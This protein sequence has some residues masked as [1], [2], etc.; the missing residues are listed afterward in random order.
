MT[1]MTSREYAQAMADQ[2]GD[3]AKCTWLTVGELLTLY[4]QID[5]CKHAH[6]YEYCSI[7]FENGEVIDDQRTVCFD[8]ESLISS[9]KQPAEIIPF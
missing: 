5:W 8:C 7:R 3:N 2:F 1:R 6:T 9:I 4:G